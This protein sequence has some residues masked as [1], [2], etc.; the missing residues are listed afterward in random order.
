MSKL[1]YP[2]VLLKI[3]GEAL[4]GSKGYGIDADALAAICREIKNTYDQGVQL[5]VVIGAGNIWR[6]RMGEQMDRV[7][8]DHMGMLATTINSLA[9]QDGLEALKVPCRVQTA[10]EMRQFAE[11]YIQRKA[12]SH[13]D[14]GRVVIFGCGTGNPF[15][16]TDTAAALR[17]S[18][19][20]ANVLL[21]AT[22]VDGVYTADPK[23]DPNAKRYR[24]LKSIDALTQN[25]HVADTT[26][27]SMCMDTHLP[28]LV[29][30]AHKEGN[31]LKA[32]LGEDIGTVVSDQTE[33]C[34]Y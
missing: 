12:I 8:A 11:P 26:A 19:I 4:A 14:K 30:D 6:G 5:G 22:N 15:V 31:I 7:N 16:T 24:T 10:I 13:L 28:I 17:A 21:K 25:L 23:K 18:E 20:H 34:F 9:L 2:R 3:S 29:F 27:F 33:T 1:R 32:C